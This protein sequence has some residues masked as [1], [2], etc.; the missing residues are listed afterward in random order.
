[1]WNEG[2]R[3]CTHTPEGIPLAA[4]FFPDLDPRVRARTLPINEVSAGMQWIGTHAGTPIVLIRTQGCDV[5]CPYCD[6][7]E[8]WHDSKV[9]L[10]PD[11]IRRVMRWRDLTAGELI[12]WAREN[13]KHLRHVL[14]TGGEPAMHE[15]TGELARQ[16]LAAGYFVQYE[17]SGTRVLP[18]SLP[19]RTWV[20]V[21]PK[22]YMPGRRVV[23]KEVLQRA[24]EIVMPLAYERDLKALQQEVIPVLRRGVS[25]YLHPV[26][27]GGAS[28][29]ALKEAFA[30]GYRVTVRVHELSK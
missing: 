15:E 28:A 24:N 26:R 14:I 19:E 8:A 16:F 5:G 1:M 25:V 21:S 11:W 17:T 12:E 29:S 7:P 22:F 9:S 2:S 27:G 20:T 18:L 4:L 23:L 30:R 3:V 13:Y 6:A 10:R